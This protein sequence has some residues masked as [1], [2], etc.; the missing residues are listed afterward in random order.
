MGD[1]S[2][3]MWYVGFPPKASSVSTGLGAE[4]REEGE[5][6]EAVR[7]GSTC[8]DGRGAVFEV[9]LFRSS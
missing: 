1:M 8:N 4:T 3:S 6:E 7:L 2:I 5:K 9:G